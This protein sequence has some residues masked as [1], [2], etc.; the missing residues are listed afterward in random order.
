MSYAYKTKNENF[1]IPDKK[2]TYRFIDKNGKHIRFVDQDEL[3]Y[4]VRVLQPINLDD[5]PKILD[6]KNHE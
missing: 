5:I 4:L 6:K 2:N 3:D 1:L